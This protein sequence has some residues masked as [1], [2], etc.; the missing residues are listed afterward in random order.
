MA[1]GASILLYGMNSGVLPDGRRYDGYISAVND[2]VSARQQN[3]NVVAVN[4]SFGMPLASNSSVSQ[5]FTR[6]QCAAYD[7]V[8]S[9]LIELL[10]AA[11]V[12]VVAAAGNDGYR[13]GLAKPA[14][15]PGVVAVG[16][17]Y[18]EDQRIPGY[19]YE[20]S[21]PAI[22]PDASCIDVNPVVKQPLCFTNVSADIDIWAPGY[23]ISAQTPGTGAWTTMKGTSM[24]SPHV[25]GAIALLRQRFPAAT[26]DEVERY[27]TECLPRTVVYGG[28]SRPFLAV[29]TESLCPTTGVM[30]GPNP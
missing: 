4:M 28:T 26:W 30:G 1:P 19:G 14:C 18:G 27:L 29:D 17:T 24:A 5:K 8:W 3:R 15:L 23:E 11:H 25:A 6:A 21:L 7:S 10:H 22:G 13:D 2:I 16:A 12:S 9:P 20:W